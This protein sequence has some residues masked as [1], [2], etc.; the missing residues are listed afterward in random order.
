VTHFSV[1]APASATAG[2]AFSFTVTALDASDTIV[3]GYT[4]TVHFTSSD[5]QA[6]LPADTTLTIGTGT[7]NATLKTAGSQTITATDTINTSITGT[8][9]TIAVSPAA[10][11]HF[12]VVA[13]AT[14]TANTSFNFTV[15]A[16]DQFNNTATGYTGTVHFT[17]TDAQ[18]VLPADS[19]LT[20]GAGVFSATLKATGNQTIT[21]TD[22]V[23]SSITGTSNTISVTSRAIV[24]IGADDGV[25]GIV[26]VF[27]AQTHAQVFSFFPFGSG[28][29]H[30][31][32]VAVA[33]VNDDG[34]PDIIAGGLGGRIRVFSGKTHA[35]LPGRLG[36]FRAFGQGFP[37]Q[38]FVAAGDLNGDGH[39][40]I[41]VGQGLNTPS[42]VS[43]FSGA[44]GGVLRSFTAFPGF[45]GGVRVAVGDVNGDGQHDIIVA[46]GRGRTA[47]VRVYNGLTPQLLSRFVAYGGGF[48][49]GVFVAAADLNGDGK[50]DII[51]GAGGV[52]LDHPGQPV[53]GNR[54]VRAFS[55]ANPHQL[56]ANFVAQPRR[57]DVDVRVAAVDV[58]G[59]G[60]PD[61]ITSFG[62]GA[63]LAPRAFNG[64]THAPLNFF[65]GNYR[66]SFVSAGS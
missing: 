39:A 5:G 11:T 53:A 59:D 33:D 37:G 6:V 58:N 28:Y 26:R 13:P 23:T 24:A 15:T 62:L 44:T 18:A 43:V 9:N 3:T 20:S 56:L 19:T 34:V 63:A 65:L 40:D 30:G 38:V 2:S 66:G 55:G 22:T 14:A 1:V 45:S 29:T 42:R 31:V 35:P 46:A 47:E 17:S 57:V 41:V 50:A 32:R 36:D 49:G 7:F 10:A 4:G 61:I 60:I 52:N 25:P 54:P 12:S 51:T 16:L 64:L 27:S 8:S 48:S 21:A